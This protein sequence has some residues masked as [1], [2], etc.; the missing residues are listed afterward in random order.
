MIIILWDSLRIDAIEPLKGI[1]KE[2]SWSKF[3]SVAGFTAPVVASVMTGKT[4]EELGLSRDTSDFLAKL[5]PEKIDDILFDYFDSYISLGRLI[6]P[7]TSLVPLPPSRRGNYKFM[8]PIPWNAV[9]NWDIDIFRYVGMKWSIANDKWWDLI[10]WHSFVTHGPWSIY[11]SM[12]AK[13][14]PEVINTDRLMRRMMEHDPEGLW[15]WYMKGVYY[16]A[17]TLRALNDITGG[18]ETIICFADHGECNPEGDIL[19]K[20]GIKDISEVEVGDE[21]YDVTGR[22]NKV[23]K[24]FKFKHRDKL[25]EIRPYGFSKCIRFTENHPILILDKSGQKIWKLAKEITKDDRLLIPIPKQNNESLDLKDYID[26]YILLGSNKV[27]KKYNHPLFENKRMIHPRVKPL[28]RDMTDENFLALCGLYVSE[29]NIGHSTGET[30]HS[31]YIAG[32]TKNIAK[33]K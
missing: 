19:T 26:N 10:Y 7:E 14:S 27:H 24:K 31:I 2:E 11:D 3:R 9:S 22:W 15:K 8:P 20:D 4:P 21:V 12:G 5:D 17:E 23:Y 30:G 25:I 13:E 1:F 28:P 6:G 18:M 29:G 33:E 16:A 32:N